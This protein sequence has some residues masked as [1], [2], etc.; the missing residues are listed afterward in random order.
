M[1]KL[2]IDQPDAKTASIATRIS[3]S[4]QDSPSIKNL[5][6]VISSIIAQEYVLI[7]K[8]NP[9]IFKESGVAK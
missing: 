3:F 9:K 2:I 6:D 4:W 7:V 5:L 1:E 8:Q